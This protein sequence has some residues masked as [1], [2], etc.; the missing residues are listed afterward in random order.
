MKQHEDPNKII[1]KSIKTS[2]S[3]T[4]KPKNLFR[5]GSDANLILDR[6]IA[7]EQNPMYNKK[8]N[9]NLTKK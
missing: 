1:L 6:L 3:K 9:D 4:K 2:K 8:L 5:D 7:G